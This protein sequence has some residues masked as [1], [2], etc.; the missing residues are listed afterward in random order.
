[1]FYKLL[2]S[3][4]HAAG[5]YLSTGSACVTIG[6]MG[7]VEKVSV[8]MSKRAAIAQLQLMVPGR[9]ADQGWPNLSIYEKQL[10]I[11]IDI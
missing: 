7:T 6:V 4:C 9:N 3:F 8:V 11:L 2:S 10:D 1:M 5:T